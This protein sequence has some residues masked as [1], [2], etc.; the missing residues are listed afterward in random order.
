VKRIVEHPVLGPLEQKPV[1][2]RFDGMTYVANEGDSIAA[3]L[4]AA[5]VRTLRH[6]PSDDAPRGIYCGIGHCY[7]C[8][9]AVDG[10][11]S[12]RACLTPVADGM[13]VESGL[14]QEP[15]PDA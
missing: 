3:A 7:E 14:A 5:G 9:V 8:R 1:S 6:S 11:A 10:R 15:D 2:F 12:V 13:T 4:L